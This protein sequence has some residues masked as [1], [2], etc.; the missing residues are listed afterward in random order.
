MADCYW[1]DSYF[2]ELDARFPRRIKSV[3]TAAKEETKNKK[4]TPG[5]L[6]FKKV[7]V[8]FAGNVVWNVALYR[9][10]IVLYR[11]YWGN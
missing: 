1:T 7:S 6:N 4:K 3:T 5:F 9:L 10:T 8:R 2:T 11:S